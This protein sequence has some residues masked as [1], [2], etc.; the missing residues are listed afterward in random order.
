MGLVSFQGKE[1]LVKQAVH[2]VGNAD[3]TA[4]SDNPLSS[5][6]SVLKPPGLCLVLK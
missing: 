2:L 5:P 3:K 6:S 4:M 1:L